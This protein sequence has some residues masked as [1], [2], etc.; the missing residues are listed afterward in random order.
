[1]AMEDYPE[2]W[3]ATRLRVMDKMFAILNNENPEKVAV[4]LKCDPEIAETLRS[5][6]PN[7]VTPGYYMNKTHWNTVYIDGELSDEKIFTMI[8]WSYNLVVKTMP[9]KLQK[10]ILESAK[11]E[12]TNEEM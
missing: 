1:M 9:K 8:D 12:K 3:D 6:Y 4:T 7:S 2:G 10:E 11:L 5:K